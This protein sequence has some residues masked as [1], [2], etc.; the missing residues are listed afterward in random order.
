MPVPA[1]QALSGGQISLILGGPGGGKSS[2]L[3]THLTRLVEQWL[4]GRGGA[5]VPVLVPAAALGGVP[6]NQALASAASAELAS[7]GLVDELS[8]EFFAIPPQRGV[9]WLVLVDGLDEIAD[10][11]ARQRVLRTVKRVAHGEDADLYRFVVTTRP[12]PETEFDE[13]DHRSHLRYDL[14]PF[15][16][17]DLATVASGWFRTLLPDPDAAAERFVQMLTRTH[18]LQLARIPLM[19]SMLCQL[20]A[21]APDRPLPSSRSQIYRDFSTLLHK[22]QH[23][24]IPAGI[25]PQHRA[26]VDRYGRNAQKGTERVLD[27]LHDLIAHLA[28][29]RRN[30]N[31]S[32]ALDIVE[33]Q[34]EARCPK[35]VPPDEWRA[36][37]S[38][39]L[40]SSGL[41]TLRAGEPDFLHQTLLEYLAARHA[42]GDPHVL[43]QALH[44]IFD[45]STTYRRST[46]VPP[47]VRR[48]PW[49]RRWYWNAPGDPSYVGF[50]LDLAQDSNP[51]AATPVLVRLASP[52]SGLQ[53][54]RFISAQIQLGTHIPRE[55]V[56]AAADLCHDLARDATASDETRTVAACTLVELRDQRAASLSHDL[57][58][59][60][61]LRDFR[62]AT[63]RKLGE[64]GD[65]RGLDVCHDL[66]LDTTLDGD[67]RLAATWNLVE[68]G[69][70]RAAEVCHHLARDTTIEGRFRLAATWNLG[71]LGD[72]RAADLCHDL[73]CDTTTDNQFR[74]AA[75]WKLALLG[76]VRTADLCHSLA[77]DTTLDSF[78][79]LA[80]AWKLVKVGDA[81]TA[82]L[83]HDLA[84]DT[85]LGNQFRL[86]AAWKLVELGDTRAP[87]LARDVA[88]DGDLWLAASW[89]LTELSDTRAEHLART[90]TL[91]GDQMLADVR[92]LMWPPSSIPMLF[93]DHMALSSS[94]DDWDL[95]RQNFEST[96]RPQKPSWLRDV[97]PPPP[98]SFDEEV[99][100]GQGSSETTCPSPPP[101]TKG[102]RNR[103]WF[104]PRRAR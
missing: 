64:L 52:R 2:L 18:L 51:E 80:A 44:E 36:F 1:E 39:C 70:P 78:H 56:H 35:R 54:C 76:D 31:T 68:L 47:G 79:R 94:P 63:A 50:L 59:D 60:P 95:A 24:L 65:P 61:A 85:T 96:S 16:T 13:L 5:A 104:A 25:Q 101:W 15:A 92:K 74:L 45:R 43:A 38:S 90:T 67:L 77:H 29:E 27:H 3:R 17:E 9:R 7:H 14:L 82:D 49:H 71:P 93:V 37:L 102:R 20:H 33:L 89:K 62:L 10:V 66:A 81:R 26:G 12:L 8:A 57:A 46:R 23:A 32:P 4:A 22:R 73:A 41:L 99:P 19:A 75:A 53:G 48:R 69:D 100:A 28:A 97:Q 40:L 91:D 55:V 11:T 87:G 103:R 86:A 6:L 42:A 72:P 83:C 30:G 58:R 84:R 21:A 98:W 88:P 34:S